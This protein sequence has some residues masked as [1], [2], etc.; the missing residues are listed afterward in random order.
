M[1]AKLLQFN[2]DVGLNY[3]KKIYATAV[4]NMPF[5]MLYILFV[6]VAI[7][8]GSL[9]TGTHWMYRVI[10]MLQ[11]NQ[12]K[13]DKRFADTAF[14]DL[15]KIEDIDQLDSPRLLVTHVPWNL[16]PIDVLAKQCRIVHVYRNPRAVLVSY[17]FQVVGLAL[18]REDYDHKDYDYN[19]FL[20]NYNDFFSDEN[21]KSYL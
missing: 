5:V 9:S 18:R 16:L 17:H 2:L 20:K 12:V 19:A 4:F 7:I 14:L 3:V 6:F 13:Y 8:F 1:S 21:S 11:R 15:Q 10:D